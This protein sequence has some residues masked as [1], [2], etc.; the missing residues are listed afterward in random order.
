[1]SDISALAS[2]DS[3]Q[4]LESLGAHRA[5]SRHQTCRCLEKITFWIND[6]HMTVAPAGLTHGSEDSRPVFSKVVLTG[7]QRN[8][9]FMIL[10]HPHKRLLSGC[11]CYDS[12][13]VLFWRS[14]KN[15]MWTSREPYWLIQVRSSIRWKRTEGVSLMNHSFSRCWTFRSLFQMEAKHRAKICL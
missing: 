8:L 5:E 7:L 2:T 12:I 11:F 6:R 3:I 14:L 9:W 13:K 4:C 15:R 1:M 10:E